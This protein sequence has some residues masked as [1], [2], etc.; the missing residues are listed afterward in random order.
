MKYA[1]KRVTYQEFLQLDLTD[2][3]PMLY[4]ILWNGVKYEILVNRVEGCRHAG[5]FGTGAVYRD[6][7]FPVFSRAGWMDLF[8]FTGIWYFDPTMYLGD[9]TIGWGYGTKERWYLEETGQLIRHI[10]SVCDIP[11]SQTLFYG[12]SGG[13][14]TS[15]MLATMLKGKATAINPQLCV[16]DFSKEHI[17]NLKR[18]VLDVGEQLISERVDVAEYISNSGYMP[19]LHLIINTAS[20]NDTEKQIPS[21]LSRLAR[22]NVDCTDRLRMDFYTAEGGHNGMPA[23]EVCICTIL[24]DLGAGVLSGDGGCKETAQMGNR[25]GQLQLLVNTRIEFAELQKQYNRLSARYAALAQSRLGRL[26]LFIWKKKNAFGKE[27][28]K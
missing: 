10:L 16:L 5:I 28:E 9:L 22:K 26:T 24:E 21:F 20:E 25:D 3:M 27:S 6:I 19:E 7:E 12:S 1:K 13:G 18:A 4:E 11:A 15:I 23:K 2:P 14:F 17:D 8:P